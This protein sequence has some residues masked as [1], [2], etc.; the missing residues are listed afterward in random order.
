[1]LKFE[2]H[3]ILKEK[4]GSESCNARLGT[5][6]TDHGAIQTPIFMP[7]GTV[8]SVKSIS[9]EDLDHCKAQIILGNTYHLYLR[10]GTDVISHM[11]GLPELIR[12][13]KPM[14]TDSDGF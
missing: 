4:K 9:V 8:G 13:K 7:V 12:W 5:I 3:K 14:L 1:M 10:P 2:F 11:H 6:T